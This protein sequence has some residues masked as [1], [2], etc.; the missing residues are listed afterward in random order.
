MKN[1][2][3]SIGKKIYRLIY[4]L[5]NK[6]KENNKIKIGILIF[7]VICLFSVIIIGNSYANKLNEKNISLKVINT[8]KEKSEEN[9]KLIDE[10]E[11]LEKEKEE[12][13]KKEKEN[14]LKEIKEKILELDPYYNIEETFGDIEKDIIHYEGVYKNLEEEKKIEESNTSIE[15]NEHIYN[16]TNNNN[17]NSNENNIRPVICLKEDINILSGDGTKQSPYILEE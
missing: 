2:F 5:K 10:K 8:N 16:N 11:K 12:K 15:E 1:L 3:R 6:I 4:N 14:K 17:S 7:L 13:I 9:K